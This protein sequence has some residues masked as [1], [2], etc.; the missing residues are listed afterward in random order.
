VPKREVIDGRGRGATP[1]EALAA[2]LAQFGV[3][4]E[5]DGT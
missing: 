4:V 2:A 5:D 3:N 1:A